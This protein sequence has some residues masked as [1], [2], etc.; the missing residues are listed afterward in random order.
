M[1]DNWVAA[2]LAL[3]ESVVQA[4]DKLI[5]HRTVTGPRYDA[6]PTSE[7]DTESA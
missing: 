6:L 5:N 1:Q 2:E 3:A 4:L 7:V